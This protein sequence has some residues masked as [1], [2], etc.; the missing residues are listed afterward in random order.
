MSNFHQCA[1]GENPIIQYV[2]FARTY[3]RV[4]G[5]YEKDVSYV[6]HVSFIAG[7]HR[8]RRTRNFV[9]KQYIRARAR[10]IHIEKSGVVCIF[11]VEGHDIIK[12]A[13]GLDSRTVGVK[14][15][16]LDIAVDGFVPL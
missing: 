15:N 8:T 1:S 11:V 16:G 2:S 10:M 13:L 12:H 4:I 5:Q 9:F 6:S 7:T 14:R 3:A